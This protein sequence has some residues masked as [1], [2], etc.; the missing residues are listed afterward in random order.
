MKFCRIDLSK[1]NYQLYPNTEILTYPQMEVMN[2]IYRSYCKYKQFESVMPLF[3]NDVL[4]TRVDVHGYYNNQDELV[5]FDLVKKLD[6][7]NIESVQFAW[8]YHEP[9]LRLG[10]IS[11]HHECAYYKNRGYKYLYLGEYSHYKSQIDGFEIL[12][13]ISE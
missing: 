11:L 5:A 7:Q 6:E 8:N 9:E 1:T 12:K 10:I 3:K 4:D 13:N 2:S